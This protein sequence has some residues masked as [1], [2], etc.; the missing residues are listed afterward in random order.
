[1]VC[2]NGCQY[3]GDRYCSQRTGRRK[4]DSGIVASSGISDFCDPVSDVGSTCMDTGRNGTFAGS[5]DSVFGNRRVL[6]AA[7]VEQSK[8]LRG[9][10]RKQPEK[11][12]SPCQRETDVGMDLACGDIYQSGGNGGI[13]LADFPERI[14]GYGGSDHLCPVKSGRWRIYSCSAPVDDEKAA[15]DFEGRRAVFLRG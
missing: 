3:C 10:Q 4:A 14:F 7:C 13:A 11:Y 2:R 15:G 6:G 8:A 9:V 12:S 1:M 5:G